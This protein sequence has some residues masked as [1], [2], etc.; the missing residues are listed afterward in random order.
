MRDT[1]F[2]GGI[3]PLSLRE[4][5]AL[6]AYLVPVVICFTRLSLGGGYSFLLISNTLAAPLCFLSAPSGYDA[7]AVVGGGVPFLPRRP[8]GA[9]LLLG[10]GFPRP[11]EARLLVQSEGF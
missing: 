4:A 6:F 3:L 9:E 5:V 10:P 2:V 7:M 11:R 8:F 1:L